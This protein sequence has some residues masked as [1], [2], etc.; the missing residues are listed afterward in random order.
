[1]EDPYLIRFRL[2]KMGRERGLGS[3]GGPFVANVANKIYFLTDSAI[4]NY[5]TQ[6]G[7]FVADSTFGTFPNGGGKDQAYIGED[8]KKRV[9]VVLG[10]TLRIATPLSTGGYKVDSTAFLPI[11]WRTIS[12]VYP[13]A[14]GI[15]WICTSDGLFRYDE[16]RV[17]NYDL[18][19]KTLLRFIS[20]GKTRLNTMGPKIFSSTI[21]T[22]PFDRAHFYEYEQEHSTNT[23][24]GF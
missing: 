5:N 13:E 9:W 16:H 1:M 22:A 23:A 20:A 2:Q 19:F 15:D 17:K 6:T 4:F 3:G 10:K 18:P 7:R 21:A 14:N 12:Y 24:G 8:Y 11:S